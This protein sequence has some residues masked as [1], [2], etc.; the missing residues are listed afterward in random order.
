MVNEETIITAE[1]IMHDHKK[2]KSSSAKVVIREANN[3]SRR[4]H[5]RDQ[6]GPWIE[7]KNAGGSVIRFWCA[8]ARG[9][10]GSG[11]RDEFKEECVT[12]ELFEGAWESSHP[13]LLH[14]FFLPSEKI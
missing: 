6:A 9:G 13:K 8:H 7:K 12:C 5:L 1:Q 2:A 14:A 11:R 4:T 3:M 10:T